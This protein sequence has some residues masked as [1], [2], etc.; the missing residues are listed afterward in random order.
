[1]QFICMCV[2]PKNH[3]CEDQTELTMVPLKMLFPEFSILLS[4][5]YLNEFGPL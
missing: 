5:S 2:E 3:K 1:M 4:G